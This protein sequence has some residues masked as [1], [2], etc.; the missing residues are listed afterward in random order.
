MDEIQKGQMKHLRCEVLEAVIGAFPTSGRH[1]KMYT[2]ALVSDGKRDEALASLEKVL[3]MIPQLDLWKQFL[4]LTNMSCSGEASV[5]AKAYERAVDAVGHDINGNSLW[6]EYLTFLK[7]Q[8]VNN[9]YEDGQRKNQMRRAYQRLLQVPMHGVDR[10]WS[11]Y[12]QWEKSLDPNNVAQAEQLV[13][14]F[15]PKHKAARAAYKDRNRLRTA[16]T[17]PVF[18]A[19]YTGDAKDKANAKAWLDLI[20]FERSNPQKMLA[21]DLRKRVH[22][23]YMHSLS[24]V[25]LYPDI[26]HQ[27]A[28]WHGEIGDLKGEIKVP[29]PSLQ[30][31][32]SIMPH[33]DV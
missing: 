28:L 12:D 23:S 22:F 26:W 16:I 5:M 25:P 13:R 14:A 15:E 29:N 10:F 24:Y 1:W 17:L 32:Q 19:P 33:T 20:A 2:E 4:S 27:A 18:P 3:P 21:E 11:E 8:K 7:N 30:A 6:G 31:Q 9:L